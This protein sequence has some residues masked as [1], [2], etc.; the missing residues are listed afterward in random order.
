MKFEIEIIQ[1]QILLQIT[2]LINIWAAKM[3]NVVELRKITIDIRNQYFRSPGDLDESTWEIA[4]MAMTKVEN[5]EVKL[6]GELP[7]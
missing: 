2:T 7:L 1:H 6:T 4:K 5:K 3:A